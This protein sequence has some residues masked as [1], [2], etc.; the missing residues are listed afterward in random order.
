MYIASRSSPDKASHEDEE[1]VYY[2]EMSKQI[3]ISPIRSI[4]NPLSAT[5]AI[6]GQIVE[7]FKTIG[8]NYHSVVSTIDPDSFEKVASLFGLEFE[9]NKLTKNSLPVISF[10][11]GHGNVKYEF[12]QDEYVINSKAHPNICVLAFKTWYRSVNKSRRI[13]TIGGAFARRYATKIRMTKSGTD[14]VGFV[15]YKRVEQVRN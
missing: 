10:G 2:Y 15:Q 8:F 14:E 13:W 3:F 12:T 7:G 5:I 11:F 4:D 1:R 9:C 6:N